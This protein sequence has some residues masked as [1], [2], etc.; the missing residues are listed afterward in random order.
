MKPNFRSRPTLTSLTLFLGLQMLSV[1]AQNFTWDGG[2]DNFTAARWNGGAGLVTWPGAGNNAIIPSG[3]VAVDQAWAVNAITM[4]G[5]SLGLVGPAAS[6]SAGFPLIIASAADPASVVLNGGTVNRSQIDIGQGTGVGRLR[7]TNGAVV[8]V[9]GEIW[10]G[11]NANAVGFG[12]LTIANG[13]LTTGSWLAIGRGGAGASGFDTRGVLNVEGGTLNV[14]QGGNLSIGAFRVATTATSQMNLSGGTVNVGRGIFVGENANGYLDVSGGQLNISTQA[15]DVGL[16]LRGIMNLRGG[17]VSTPWVVRRAGGEGILNFNGGIL[18]AR[19][20][21]VNFLGGLGQAQ[22]FAGGA[23]I[24]SGE[25]DITIAQALNGASG[26]GVSADGLIITGGSGYTAAPI[27]EISGGG[28]S[29]ATA[30]AI[31]TDGAVTGIEITNPGTGYVSAP[32]FNLFGGGGTGASIG[33]TATLVTNESG[34]LTKNGS[35]RLT[36]SGSSSYAGTTQVN[37]GTLVVNGALSSDINV[38]DGANLGGAGSTTSSLTMKGNHQFFFNPAAAGSFVASAIDVEGGTIRVIPDGAFTPVTNKVILAS[39]DPIQGQISNFQSGNPRLTLSLNGTG[40]ELLASYTPANLVWTGGDANLPNAWNVNNA[41]NWAG[42]NVYIQGDGVTFDDSAPADS[43]V[44]VELEENVTPSSVTFANLNK[45]Y[46]LS[47]S[48]IAGATGVLVNGGANV[49]LANT[50]TFTGA[51]TVRAGTL[52]V[53]GAIATGAPL[54]V[55]DTTGG[56]AAF[57]SSGTVERTQMIFGDVDGSIGAGYQTAGT[58]RTT[59]GGGGS[60]S[61]GHRQGAFGFYRI[62][63]GTLITDEIAIGTWGTAIGNN[64]GG[65]GLMEITGGTVTNTGWMVMNR[66]EGAAAPSQQAG[67]HV[68]G[69]SLTYAG[70]GLVA[71]WSSSGN[72]QTA[73]ITVSGTGSIATVPVTN[74]PI[75]LS[76]NGNA[77]NVGI[78]NLNGGFVTPSAVIGTRGFVNFNGGVLRA[79]ATNANFL[80]VNTAR[81]FPGGAVIDTN[82]QNITIAQPLLAPTGDGISARG[83]IVEGSGYVSPPLVEISGG[84][85]FGATAVASIDAAGNLTGITIT[86]PGVNYTSTPTFTLVGG[87]G[88]GSITGTATLVPNNS[89]GLTKNGAGTLSITGQN[90]YAGATVVNV[91]T[92]SLG[93]GTT[94]TNLADAADVSIA[95]GAVLNLNYNGTDV[96]DELELG[97]VQQPAGVYDATHPS[98]SIT[99]AGSLTVTRGPSTSDYLTWADSFQP[100]IGL[101]T[102]DDDGDGLTNFSEYA[103]GLNP[104]SASSVNPISLPLDQATGQFKFTR[105][106]TPATTNVTYTFE[107]STTLSGTWPTFVPLSQTSNNGTPIE[108]ITVT[109]PSAL[110]TEP[111]LFLRV[112]ADQP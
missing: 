11:A 70:G 68:S 56:K 72:A 94:N 103:F 53:T 110:L 9:A 41:I 77:A 44:L 3:S 60:T 95:S 17:V 1:Q 81:V 28:G 93:N 43:P 20:S 84:G 5:G 99:G 102:A 37:D 104:Q 29:G 2:T 88:T 49:I 21:N 19:Q 33:G 112:K 74:A 96:I 32:T 15:V 8:N 34:G 48:A 46:E 91:G 45:S 78:L 89:G 79:N 66:S 111:K 98:G 108:E 57:R 76:Q 42:G 58:V 51:T 35:G 62:S 54:V 92:L 13:T 40:T 97:G 25:H 38:A 83:L 6:I 64:L 52:E 18:Q 10:L 69:G 87:G 4:S 71:N 22:V 31:V 100:P 86:N 82:N 101:A 30:R 67:L 36:L 75:N 23:I 16:Q 24:D 73:Q 59:V 47:G 61:L 80:A 109:L 63:G 27:V 105:R 26:E 55:G 90:S 14:G 85:G 7:L 107:Y 106:A 65:S 39:A 50:N 12:E